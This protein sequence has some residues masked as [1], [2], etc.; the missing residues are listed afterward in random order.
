MRLALA[1]NP[2]ACE[3]LDITVAVETMQCRKSCTTPAAM[4]QPHAAADNDGGDALIDIV[5]EAAGHGP[6]SRDC[7]VCM[8]PAE[9]VAVG[10]CGHGEVCVDCAF[11]MRFVERDW[12]CCICRAFCPTVVVTK[13]AAAAGDGGEQQDDGAASP[14]RPW[15]PAARARWA[16]PSRITAAW[17]PTST[18]EASMIG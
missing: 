12:L 13:P 7:P 8:E 9:W 17:L 14:A 16:R 6:T 1:C 18:T 3:S 10:P 4:A 2:D 15:R 5:V 11:R